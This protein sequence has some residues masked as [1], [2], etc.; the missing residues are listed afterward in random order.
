MEDGSLA[1]PVHRVDLA[2]HAQDESARATPAY[3]P[4][5]D[6]PL[7]EHGAEQAR[8]AAKHLAAD[9]AGIVH[10]P[11][12]RA[13]QTAKLFSEIFSLPLLTELPCLSEWR[14][15]SS[16]YGKPPDQYDDEYR[17]W[18]YART[19]DPGLAYQDGESLLA[20]HERAQFAVHELSRLAAEKGPLL[21]V[22][23]KVFLG[24]ITARSHG[25]AEAFQ[26][27]TSEPWAHCEVRTLHIRPQPDTEA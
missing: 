20:L 2:R 7:T 4:R 5:P 8:E 9:Y 16:V 17:R 1:N 12:L 11:I 21:I 25:P 10:S 23:H 19:E 22:S 26:R 27:A 18:R 24:V 3:H 15:P 13:Q 6:S 14:P